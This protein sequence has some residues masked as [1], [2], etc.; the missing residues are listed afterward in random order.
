MIALLFSVLHEG[1]KLLN[2]RE[3]NKLSNEIMELKKEWLNE[4]SKPRN[5]RSNADLDD[6]ELRLE[7]IARTFINT[8]GVAKT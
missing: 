2:T 7:L 6:M 1:L 3:S 5:L 8:V 4:Y